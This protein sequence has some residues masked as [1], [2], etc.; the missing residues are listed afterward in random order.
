[1]DIGDRCK[2]MGSGTVEIFTGRER[3][4]CWSVADKLHILNECDAPCAQVAEVAPST[5]ST[6]A[7]HPQDYLLRVLGRIVQHPVNRVAKLL[8]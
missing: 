8:P 7:W 4:R 2:V 6:A 3:R 5:E 1:M